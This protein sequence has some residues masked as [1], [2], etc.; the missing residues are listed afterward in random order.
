[1]SSRRSP[2]SPSRAALG[3]LST[4]VLA[5]ACS[6][7][8]DSRAPGSGA[9]AEDAPTSSEPRTARIEQCTPMQFESSSD[10]SRSSG[11]SD[12]PARPRRLRAASSI[13]AFAGGLAVVQDDAR[14]LGLLRG[15]DA[16]AIVLPEAD[17]HVASLDEGPVLKKEKLDLESAVHLPASGARAGRLVVLGSGSTKRREWIATVDEASLAPRLVDG[18]ALYEA[19]RALPALGEAKLNIE[20]VIAEGD[21]LRLFHRANGKKRGPSSLVIDVDHDAFVRWLDAD[22]PVPEPLSAEPIDLGEVG[23]VPFGFT[24][25]TRHAGTTVF[26][27]VAEASKDAVADGPIRGVRIGTLDASRANAVDVLEPSG[28]PSKRKLEG[29]AFDPSDPGLL[30]AVTDPDDADVAAERC[31]VR[32][33]GFF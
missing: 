13:T 30:V 28:E 1:M 5:L 31:N 2:W 20:G 7:P 14:F 4:C 27:A 21:R 8:A 23:G 17:G 29:L 19:L 18:H 11:S 33:A 25:A 10:A 24:D 32:L 12:G 22:G 15:D 9:H 3:L 16:L 26:L 6:K